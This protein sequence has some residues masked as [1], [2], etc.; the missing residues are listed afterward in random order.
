MGQHLIVGSIAIFTFFNISISIQ[1]CV[2]YVLLF[3]ITLTEYNVP[4]DIR[5]HFTT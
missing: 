5:S 2:L 1:L 3:L 4:V